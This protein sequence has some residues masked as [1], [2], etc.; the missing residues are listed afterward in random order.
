MFYSIWLNKFIKMGLLTRAMLAKQHVDVGG[1]LDAEEKERYAQLY[2]K[3]YEKQQSVQRYALKTEDEMSE[4]DK[5][6]LQRA[7]ADLGLIR[8]ELTDFE[9]VQASMFEHTADIKSRN[10]TITWY[11]MHL[12]YFRKGE[13][14]GA[15]LTPLF[16]GEDYDEKYESYKELEENDDEIYW[17]CIDKLSSLAT[18][19][20][21]SGVQTQEDFDSLLEE[22][23]QEMT[24]DV[25]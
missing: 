13:D 21:M 1:T 24:A 4:G 10:K 23:D 19:W 7:V 5:E 9:T 6:R 20:Y 12:A 22:V 3:L 25:G 14:E 2:V 17:K 8:K 18:I 15:E 16:R 11:L